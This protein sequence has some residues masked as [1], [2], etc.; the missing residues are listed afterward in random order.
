MGFVAVRWSGMKRSV[1]SVVCLLLATFVVSG[2]V[3][4]NADVKKMNTKFVKITE[5]YVADLDK[6]DD[7]KS[8]AKAINSYA[9]EFEMLWP[10]MQKLSEKYPELEDEKN[11]PKALEASQKEAEAVGKKMAGTFM[12]AMPYMQDPDV[13]K[14]QERLGKVMSGQ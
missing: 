4:K 14:A 12:K 3:G 11:L 7:A 13:R 9:D 1:V 6:A 8:V 2:S 10:K 5:A